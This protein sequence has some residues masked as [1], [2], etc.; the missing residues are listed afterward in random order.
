MSIKA[1]L[2]TKTPC[3]VVLEC[4]VSREKLNEA[5]ERSYKEQVKYIPIPGFRPG[6][7]PRELVEQK[8]KEAIQEYALDALVKKIIDAVIKQH[9]LEP[10]TGASMAEEIKFPEEGDLKFTVEFEVAPAVKLPEYKNLKLK[11]RKVEIKDDDVKNIIDK[12]LEQNSTL[13]DVKEDRPVAYGDWVVVDYKGETDGEEA[14]N[15][16]DA[17]IEV[18]SERKIPVQGFPEQL[19]G[20]KKG[21]SLD[22]EL[23]APTD[24][25]MKKVAGKKIKFSVEV[26]AVKEMKKPELN[27][28]LAKK[29][30][31]KCENVDALKEKIKEN[32][33]KY[34]EDEE[35]Q[36]LKELA[37]EELLRRADIPLPPTQV[38][39]RVSRL[40]EDE[41]RRRIQAGETEEQV[42]E[43]SE[44]I[45][46]KVTEVAEQQ[47]RK[48]Y[49]L[50]TIA[51]KENVK[52]TYEDIMPQLYYYSNMFRKPLAWVYKMFEREGKIN[53]LYAVAANNKALDIVLENAEISEE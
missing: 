5:Y 46:K 34:K 28:E 7:A 12:L 42:K 2:K 32:Q 45:I 33:L 10:V 41:A 35:K 21:D 52:V 49:L 38:R 36:R 19:V 25:P 47:L 53:E 23:E 30:D 13:E 24:Y 44:N 3:E 50:D 11:K 14:F 40:A 18:N 27:D 37:A 29:I 15:R 9:K 1:K 51:L 8:Y 6:K 39:N 16:K 26:K 31:P 22:F 20:A 48:E 43:D 17:W 4:E